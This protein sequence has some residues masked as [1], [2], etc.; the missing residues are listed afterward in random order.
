MNIG[1]DA[2]MAPGVREALAAMAARGAAERERERRIELA[3][4]EAE[5][6]AWRST[7]SAQGPAPAGPKRRLMGRLG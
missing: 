2:D 1:T 7:G 5:E 4:Q 3:R 6:R